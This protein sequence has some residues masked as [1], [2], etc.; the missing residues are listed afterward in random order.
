MKWTFKAGLWRLWVTHSVAARLHGSAGDSDE[1]RVERAYR[2]LFG[3]EPDRE[4]TAVAAAFLRQPTAAGLTR[5]EQYTQ[6]LLAANEMM[7]LD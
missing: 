6:M 7:Y 4:E 3:R 5:W 1:T 2:Q